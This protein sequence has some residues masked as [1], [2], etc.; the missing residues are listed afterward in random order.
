MIYDIV[1]GPPDAN[2]EW[3]IPDGLQMRLSR[4]GSA[5]IPCRPCVQIAFSI[6]TPR[7]V[8]ALFADPAVDHTPFPTVLGRVL[9]REMRQAAEGRYPET[10]FPHKPVDQIDVVAAFVEQ[11]EG[12]PLGIGPPA[13]HVI[14]SKPQIPDGLHVFDMDQLPQGTFA[15]QPLDGPIGL[16][17]P[18]R[19]THG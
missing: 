17:L 13:P 11:Q 12:V 18:Q 3:P 10:P 6:E 7:R 4:M 9:K 15:H 5:D 8:R 2:A 16:H 1:V 14:V 19:V